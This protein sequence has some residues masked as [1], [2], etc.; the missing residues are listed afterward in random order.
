MFA[1]TQRLTLRPGWCED[2]PA[3]TQAIAHESVAM[4]LARLPW[5]YGQRDA[6]AFLEMERRAGDPTFLIFRHDGGMT[7]L[8]GGIGID[9]D[10]ANGPELGYWLTPSA[11]GQ[12]YAT[13]AGRAVVAIARETLRLPRL[14]SGHFLDNP[15]SGRVLAKLGFVPTGRTE[16]RASRARRTR[17]PCATYTLDFGD[18]DT[19]V[20]R[21]AA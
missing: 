11:W 13:E 15:A 14:A 4:K 19:G 3:L 1:R 16:Q 9:M 18:P 17:V 7:A 2:A 10:G 8:I 12:G 6:E 5:P 21:M 20:D